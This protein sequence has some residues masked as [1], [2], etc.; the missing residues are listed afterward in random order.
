M[1]PVHHPARVLQTN[2]VSL[3]Y[4]LHSPPLLVNDDDAAAAAIVSLTGDSA[5]AAFAL[6]G[7]PRQDSSTVQFRVQD[8]ML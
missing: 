6:D 4:R 2:A 5:A 7:R 1:Y 3:Q 8:N